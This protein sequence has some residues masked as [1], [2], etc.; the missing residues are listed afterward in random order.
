[1]RL[2]I[3]FPVKDRTKFL[4]QSI[5][6]VLACLP[7]LE[8]HADYE[9]I[10]GDNASTE[11]VAGAARDVCPSI[12]VIRH[13]EDLGIFGNMNALIMASTGDW[14]HVV[15]DDD[16]ILPGFYAR[17]LKALEEVPEAG[18]VSILPRIVNDETGQ[19][20]AMPRWFDRTGIQKPDA[21]LAHLYTGTSF[22][23]VGML[24]A[25]PA[26]DRVGLFDQSIPHSAD[27]QKW[28]QLAA[29]VPWFYC[30]ESLCRFR[31]HKESMTSRYQSAGDIPSDIRRAIAM[32][33]VPDRLREIHRLAV[34]GWASS[35]AN[36]AKIYLGE[37]NIPLA[38]I[39]LTEAFNILALVDCDAP[40]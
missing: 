39:C 9:L 14:I 19:E 36:D 3:L 24:V 4:A 34:M 16:W 35:I 38:R 20:A 23:I 29:A 32:D 6:S 7:E 5:G 11:D 13:A 10:L 18:V 25:R 30:P 28:K 22:S 31:S 1:M 12:R 17:F 40:G 27:W 37:G 15:H 21:I 8:R 26:Y 33:V 2:S